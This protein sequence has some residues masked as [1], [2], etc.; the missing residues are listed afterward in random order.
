MGLHDWEEIP[1]AAICDSIDYGYT[2]S[3]IASPVGPRFL[4]ITDIVGGYIDWNTV[5]YCIADAETMEKYKLEDGDIVIARTGATT[6]TSAYISQPPNAVFA[7]YLVRLKI[8]KRALP[9]FVA[10]WLKSQEF[11]DYIRGV[12]GDKSAQ[13]N[14]SASTMTQAKIKLPPLPIQRAIAHILGTLDDKIE[15]NRQMNATLEAIARALFKSWFVDFDPVRAK[16]EGRQPAGM[17][18]E[19]A[20]LFPAAFVDSE[21]GKI[22][23]GWRVGKVK[24]VAKVSK[25]TIDPRNHPD[26][27]F[28]HY[29]IPAFDEGQLPKVE[30][31]SEIKSNKNLVLTESLL[32]SKLNPSTPRIWLPKVGTQHRSVCSTEFFVTLPS[33]EL[34]REYL[35]LLFGSEIFARDFA[36]KVTGTSGSHQRVQVESFLETDVVIPDAKIIACFTRSVRALLEQQAANREQSRTLAAL[37]DTLLPKLISGE[38]R[39][40]D[41]EKQIAETA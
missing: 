39:I 22:P 18:A 9:R 28:D 1:L 33:S 26:E 24:D 10:Y 23:K 2:Q 36:T 38:I 4:R 30:A 14:A 19:T 40:K 20:A 31:G 41:A 6:G 8:G 35:Y 34:S 5:P 7:S 27:L 15:L 17:D 29:S 25:Q 11:W 37:R 13:P 21:L 32:V 3:A 16:A 12:L